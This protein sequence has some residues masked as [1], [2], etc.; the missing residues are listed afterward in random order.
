MQEQIKIETIPYEPNGNYENYEKV[1]IRIIQ[2]IEEHRSRKNYIENQ[3]KNDIKPLIKTLKFVQ[4]NA[5]KDK[6][7]LNYA[8]KRFE[9]LKRQNCTEEDFQK[10][11]EACD[12]NIKALETLLN[13]YFQE[14]IRDGYAYPN[15]KAFIYCEIQSK[16]ILD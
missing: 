12:K 16:I 11:L 3:Y 4:K 14:E 10:V 15:E 5:K 8:E 1:K 7:L 13:E 9:D 6:E 2:Q